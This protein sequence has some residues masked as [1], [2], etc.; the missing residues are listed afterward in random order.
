MIVYLWL[1]L[2]IIIVLW[3]FLYF[4]SLLNKSVNPRIKAEDCTVDIPI[5]ETDLIK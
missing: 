4:I 3:L 1:Q 2:V 5:V